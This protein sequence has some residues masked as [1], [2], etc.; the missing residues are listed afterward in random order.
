MW[1]EVDQ[2]VGASFKPMNWQ[3]WVGTCQTDPRMLAIYRPALP[4][5][6]V[7]SRFTSIRGPVEI[8]SRA[9]SGRGEK[10]QSGP[11]R[12]WQSVSYLNHCGAG[13]DQFKLGSEYCFVAVSLTKKK[14]YNN[15]QREHFSLKKKYFYASAPPSKQSW[16]TFACE[17]KS[18]HKIKQSFWLIK[19]ERTYQ[20]CFSWEKKKLFLWSGKLFTWTVTYFCRGYR[21]L[22]GSLGLRFVVSD[23]EFASVGAWGERRDEFSEPVTFPGNWK[24]H[25]GAFQYTVV[26]CAGRGVGAFRLGAIAVG[27]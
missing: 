13:I 14:C 23:F 21:S 22:A 4:L 12:I 24:V 26:A 1:V 18:P 16:T 15:P 8:S 3:E 19:K 27:T 9:T 5:F 25:T 10:N 11:M 17:Q 6:P 20:S 2:M 7:S